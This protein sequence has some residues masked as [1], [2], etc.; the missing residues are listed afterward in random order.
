MPRNEL[1]YIINFHQ[2]RILAGKL[3]SICQRDPFSDADGSYLISSLYFDDYNQSA[4]LDKL[5]GVSE[6]KKFRIRVYNHQTNI[7]KLERKSKK[8]NKIEI[9]TF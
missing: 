5:T 9:E 1:K 3:D 8:K 6:R 2:K 7:I 4:L